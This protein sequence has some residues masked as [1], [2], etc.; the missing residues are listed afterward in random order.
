MK[1]LVPTDFSE[2]A[3]SAAKTAMDIGLLSKGELYFMH[4]LGD[5][6]GPAHKTIHGGK[7]K[8]VHSTEE[9]I[10]KASLDQLVA[11]AERQGLKA[12]AEL[13]FG[14]S[15]D[16]IWKYVKS[17]GIELI[18]MG[19]HGATGIRETFIGSN[20]QRVVRNAVV[21]VL[22]IKKRTKKFSV[23]QIVFASG[24]SEQP[25]LPLH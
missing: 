6:P 20:T 19:S 25:S 3:S 2:C 14:Q 22:V 11:E 5:L 13:V 1:I 16:E 8:P 7:T 18:V 15:G 4:L 23:N 24:F 12:H 10:A 9:G 17:L 21:P